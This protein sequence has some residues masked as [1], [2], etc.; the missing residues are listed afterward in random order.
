MKKI[1]EE[2]AL[3]ERFEKALA[4]HES[5][6]KVIANKV[7]MSNPMA[8]LN[9]LADIQSV[10]ALAAQS[11][12]MLTY[13]T[14]KFTLRKL[15]KLNMENMGAMEKKSVLSSEIGDVSFW[16][17]VSELLIKEMHYQIDILRSALSYCKQEM[18]NLN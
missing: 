16:D 12:S 15:T 8:V 17:N 14:E 6:R 10:Q 3:Q 13:L 11:K 18:N 9:Q 5:V 2:D 4:M 1:F 7:D